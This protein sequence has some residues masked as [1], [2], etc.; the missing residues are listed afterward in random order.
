MRS[1]IKGKLYNTD[2][3][4]KIGKFGEEELFRKK[5]GEFF[6]YD[7]KIGVKPLT[8]EDAKIWVKKYLKEDIYI[9]LFCGTRE[10]KTASDKLRKIR[11]MTGY[12]QSKFADVYEI[13]V[14][15]IKSWEMGDRIPPTYV[16]N[17]LEFKVRH[18]FKIK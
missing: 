11:E 17:L 15:T 13:P 7:T 18:D 5:T 8:K 14:R 1:I 16:L 12:T 3:A 9:S 10:Q 6:K 2:T 4:I